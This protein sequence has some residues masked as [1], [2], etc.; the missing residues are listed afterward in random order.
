MFKMVVVITSTIF[1]PVSN[2][3]DIRSVFSPAERL[4]QTKGT[5]KSLLDCGYN[6]IYL[7]DN[8][9]SYWVKDTEAE[10]FPAKVFVFNQHQYKNKGI[11]ETLML[12]DGLEHLPE[13]TQIMKIS[14]RYKLSKHQDT[15]MNDFDIAARFSTHKF[16]YFTTRIT[17]ATRCY[18]VRD[19]SVYQTYLS[20]MLEEIYSYSSKIVG[21]GSLK[22][23][24]NNQFSPKKNKYDFFDPA[25]SVEAASVRVIKKLKLKI[26]NIKK[27]G[28][29]GYAGTFNNLLIE[30]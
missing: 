23:F 9:G 6:E 14:G 12:V 8:S 22:R 11:S 17:M 2:S 25:L 5:I 21:I 15:D 4:D 26:Y 20:A 10:L 24:L 28:L 1:P 27:I 16:K 3:G 30:D 18:L 29:S 7:F 19:K 13:G